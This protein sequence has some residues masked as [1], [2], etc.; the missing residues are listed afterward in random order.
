MAAIGGHTQ[1]LKLAQ[2]IFYLALRA[3]RVNIFSMSAD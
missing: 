3:C 1:L 2:N